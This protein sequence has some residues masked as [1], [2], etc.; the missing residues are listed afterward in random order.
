MDGKE[1]VYAAA[2]KRESQ[3]ELSKFVPESTQAKTHERQSG[4]KKKA[5]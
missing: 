2:I 4:T 5:S 3:P 1:H